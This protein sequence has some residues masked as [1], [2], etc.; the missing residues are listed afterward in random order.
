M[1]NVIHTET[2]FV[3]GQKPD[4]GPYQHEAVADAYAQQLIALGW[5]TRTD[6]PSHD[7]ILHAEI[8]DATCQGPCEACGRR[9]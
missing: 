1:C 8:H 3:N 7:D 9:S 2:C 5:I 4:H 6:T